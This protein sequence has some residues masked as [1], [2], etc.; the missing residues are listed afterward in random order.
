MLGYGINTLKMSEFQIQAV[1]FPKNDGIFQNEKNRFKFLDELG[2]VPIKKVDTK[3][4][5]NYYSYR[6]KEPEQFNQYVAKKL[7]NEVLLIMG[8]TIN[9]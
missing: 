4:Y 8:R 7:P 2:V 6:I 3:A 9:Q 1:R 5:K